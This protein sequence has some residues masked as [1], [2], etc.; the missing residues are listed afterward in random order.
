M[1]KLNLASIFKRGNHGV[2]YGLSEMTNS[3]APPRDFMIVVCTCSG[4]PIFAIP[5]NAQIPQTVYPL[6]S[7]VTRTS[8]AAETARSSVIKLET[9]THYMWIRRVKSLILFIAFRK[10]LLKFVLKCMRA[11]TEEVSRL[12]EDELIKQGIVYETS[13]SEYKVRLV[14]RVLVELISY[15]I[16]VLRSAGT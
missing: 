10:E 14:E 9:E 13:I 5:S 3:S 2:M 11:I 4:V 1:W 15:V 16:S 6:I 8:E 7:I 12:A